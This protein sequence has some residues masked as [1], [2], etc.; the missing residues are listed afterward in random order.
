[1]RLNENQIRRLIRESLKKIV[2]EGVCDERTGDGP[3]GIVTIIQ[4]SGEY[5]L[6]YGDRILYDP[7]GGKYYPS[8]DM[9]QKMFRSY[10]ECKS[11]CDQ[12][13]IKILQDSTVKSPFSVSSPDPRSVF[14]G[15]R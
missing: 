11:F 12:N 2:R 3:Y 15:R 7:R 6:D 13:G 10:Q 4:M 14:P 8:S 5:R 1:M 9:E